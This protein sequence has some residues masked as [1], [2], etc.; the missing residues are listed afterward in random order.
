MKQ[1][2]PLQN[3]PETSSSADKKFV[4]VCSTCGEKH[5][6]FHPLV[7]CVN[8]NKARAKAKEEKRSL[9]EA[10]KKAD[11]EAKAR[12]HAEKNAILEAQENAKYQARLR[13][14]AEKQL[15]AADEYIRAKACI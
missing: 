1:Q 7:P 6:P 3:H 14:E 5:W 8:V 9:A 12:A 2:E 10:R 4:P 15:E 11:A 13:V